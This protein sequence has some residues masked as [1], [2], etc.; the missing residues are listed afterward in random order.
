MSIEE[1]MNLEVYSVTKRKEPAFSTP[2]ALFVITQ[3]D[4]RRSG[5]TSIP[6]ALRLTPG[7]LVAR[8][9]ANNYMISFNDQPYTQKLLVLVDGRPVHSS[10]FS[11]MFWPSVNVFMEDIEKIEVI[12]GAASAVWGDNAITGVISVITKN[13]GATEGA[14]VAASGGDLGKYAARARYGYSSGA[15]SGRFYFMAEGADVGRKFIPAS[16]P[17]DG[18]KMFNKRLVT[19]A[20]FR[21]DWDDPSARTTF[22]GDLYSNTI[23][24][25]GAIF[26]DYHSPTAHF[27][28]EDGYTGGNL[29]LRREADYGTASS[30][31]QLM[32]NRATMERKYFKETLDTAEAEAQLDYRGLDGH[33]ISFG[34][35]ARGMKSDFTPT[36][37]FYLPD[38]QNNLYGLF[39]EDRI[40][41]TDQLSFWLGVKY[42]RNSFTGWQFQPQAKAIWTMDTAAAWIS[43]SRAIRLRDTVTTNIFWNWESDNLNGVFPGIDTD[44]W[45]ITRIVGSMDFEPEE[46]ISY[47][48][49]LRA[50]PGQ[51]FGFDISAYYNI[52]PN[53]ADTAASGDPFFEE[54]P[55]PH[56]VQ[57]ATVQNP[58]EGESAGAKIMFTAD[59]AFWARIKGGVSTARIWARPKPGFEYNQ[60]SVDY[61]S[62][63]L[64]K[65]QAVIGLR[66][67]LP[68]RVKLD[69]TFYTVAAMPSLD[70]EQ[71]HR[72]DVRLSYQPAPGWEISLTG[73]NLLQ[74]RHMEYPWAYLEETSFV[75]RD[76]Y[77]KVTYGAF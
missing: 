34:A 57:N 32:A 40:S 30:T 33:Q 62:N 59:L 51:S 22:Q 23:G 42:E 10:T 11:Q 56:Y 75:I 43:T 70:I 49:G 8:T 31:I 16:E 55:E 52:Y 39:V 76:F 4:I 54:N 12:L 27:E 17:I 67:D 41:A 68:G 15:N 69:P 73:R 9:D 65:Y 21:M 24:S 72:L 14:A 45:G 46:T 58:T 29:I 37:A 18:G 48:A 64:P 74:Q 44:I 66:L 36:E 35:N 2:S 60:G 6:E 38:I 5:A 61:V 13:S 71:Y 47:E 19:Q 77:L 1:L 26:I 7:L 25:E 50:H 3:E 53:I 63:M 20:G 28:H